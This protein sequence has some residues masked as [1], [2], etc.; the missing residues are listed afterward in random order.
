MISIDIEILKLQHF[1]CMARRQGM[2]RHLHIQCPLFSKW[3]GWDPVNRLNHTS[4]V[5]IVILIDRP[6]LVRNRCVMEIFGGVF[7]LSRM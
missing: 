3:E 7:V 5:A 4:W 1:L 2:Q 6:K